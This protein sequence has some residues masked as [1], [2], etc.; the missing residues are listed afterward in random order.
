MGQPWHLVAGTARG[1]SGKDEVCRRSGGDVA[2]GQGQEGRPG[3]KEE[4]SDASGH[5]D[6][7]AASGRPEEGAGPGTAASLALR[8]MRW[9]RWPRGS[10]AQQGG[11][12]PQRCPARLAFCSARRALFLP[13]LQRKR[14]QHR[15]LS[16][17]TCPA[18]GTSPRGILR[19]D[20]S[21]TALVS[22]GPC[23]ARASSVPS[24]L[25]AQLCCETQQ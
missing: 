10:H 17:A 8:G 4:P 5:G 9:P 13:G 12:K 24:H 22:P 23:P 3:G 18:S 2:L 21:G 16:S 19:A 25:A 11:R 15:F 6:K 1:D 7:G 20:G 14:G